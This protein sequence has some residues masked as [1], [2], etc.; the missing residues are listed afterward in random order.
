M[1]HLALEMP[2]PVLQA[3]VRLAEGG[4][5]PA[6][7]GPLPPAQAPAAAA[8]VA[9]PPLAGPGVRSQGTPGAMPGAEAD[10]GHGRGPRVLVLVTE[11]GSGS[12]AGSVGVLAARV[13]RGI[14][15]GAGRAPVDR[16]GTGGAGA[17]FHEAMGGVRGATCR[18]RGPVEGSGEAEPATCLHPDEGALTGVVVAAGTAAAAGSESPR[19]GSEVAPV[20]HLLSGVQR[21]RVLLSAAVGSGRWASSPHVPGAVTAV[22]AAMASC[23]Q[24]EGCATNPGTVLGGRRKRMARFSGSSVQ[25]GMQRGMGS[26]RLA[27]QVVAADLLPP[28]LQRALV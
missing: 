10:P 22:L 26:A 11:R 4:G 7:A 3:G 21:G 15:A 28:L 19:K 13:R 12:A 18:L 5:H 16:K 24:R 8:V 17:A 14:V 2:G 20:P 6:A 25:P 1:P 23:K 27:W 9:A